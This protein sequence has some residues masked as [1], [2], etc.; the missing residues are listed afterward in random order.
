MSRDHVKQ[1][2]GDWVVFVIM[3]AL[4]FSNVK[5]QPSR[6]IVVDRPRASDPI[7]RALR[8]AF[9]LDGCLPSDM[10]HLLQRLDSAP[11]T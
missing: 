10:K 1:Q 6:G 8:N 11:F 9:D 4:P 3:A 5:A 2:I 7:G